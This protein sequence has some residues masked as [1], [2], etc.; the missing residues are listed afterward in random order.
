VRA[1]DYAL[2]GDSYYARTDGHNAPYNRRIDGSLS[3][4]WCRR[5]VA[6]MLARVNERLM[7]QGVELYLF[8][9][10]RPIACQ[11][12]LW[13]FFYEQGR[14]VLGAQATVEQLQHYAATYASDPSGFDRSNP[15]TWPAH[16][17]G[18]AVDL[19]LR[20]RKTGELLAMGAGFD[21]GAES[22]ASD[23]YERLCRD[24]EA[25]PDILRVRD[26][27]RRLYTAMAAEGFVNYPHEFWHWDWGTQF[28]VFNRSKM[29]GREVSEAAFYGY[30]DLPD[31]F[32]A[33]SARA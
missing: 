23:Y 10:Y 12:Q 11:K 19:T 7:P 25:A 32:Q 18:G 27:R 21:D 33:F 5:Q 13:A 6:A 26:N 2:A 3:D 22:S 1:C 9:A 30:C 15:F 4:I 20:D 17:T 29:E 8:D 24:G 28:A 16:S 31:S 14:T